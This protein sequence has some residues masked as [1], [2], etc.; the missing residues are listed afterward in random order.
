T[1]FPPTSCATEARSVKD[2]ATFKSANAGAAASKRTS[3]ANIERVRDFMKSSSIRMGRVVP[4][5]VAHLDRDPIIGRVD[6]GV[7]LG[8]AVLESNEGELRGHPRDV[9]G[10]PVHLRRHGISGVVDHEVRE[11][12]A[13]LLPAD[14]RPPDLREAVLEGR[15]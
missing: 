9:G 6:A 7:G 15:V 1:C 10:S 5:R 4:D 13:G 3:I 8:M 11:A 14:A 12:L 2:V